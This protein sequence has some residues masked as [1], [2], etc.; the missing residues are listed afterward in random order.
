LEG[1][2]EGGLITGGGAVPLDVAGRFE[3]LHLLFSPHRLTHGFGEAARLRSLSIMIA[4][5]VTK[6]PDH[7]LASV[8][9]EEHHMPGEKHQYDVDAMIC[10]EEPI[11]SL[12]IIMA[13]SENNSATKTAIICLGFSIL[14]LI[15]SALNLSCVLR[16]N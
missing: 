4:R 2:A 13:S 15:V 12:A 9:A 8:V 1:A 10:Y 6:H 3:A 5:D 14:I 16:S 7:T 11:G